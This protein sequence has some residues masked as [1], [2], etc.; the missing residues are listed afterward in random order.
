[1]VSVFIQDKTITIKMAKG[2]KIDRTVVKS[3]PTCEKQIPVACKSCACGYSFPCR[4]LSGTSEGK[5]SPTEKE[6]MP[7]QTRSVRTKRV[8]PDFF[9]PLDIEYTS[10]RFRTKS[11]SK[12]ESVHESPKKRRGRPKGSLNRS[13]SED[14]TKEVKPPPEEDMFANVPPEK[15]LQYSI[16]LAELN[17]KMSIQNFKPF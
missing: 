2:K 5:E 1:M 15:A 10:K 14:K 17:R 6:D 8:R 3:C 12:S 9:N 4:R 16:V 11:E 7:K 13:K